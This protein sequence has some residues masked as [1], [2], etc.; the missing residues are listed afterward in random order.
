MSFVIE[1]VERP[2]RR[3]REDEAFQATIVGPGASVG[4]LGTHQRGHGPLR[5]HFGITLTAIEP[6]RRLR[7]LSDCY[8]GAR[9]GG[10]RRCNDSGNRPEERSVAVCCCCC[11]CSTLAL[12]LFAT[13]HAKK[14]AASFHSLQYFLSLLFL[15]SLY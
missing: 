5:S 6:K 14:W 4:Q 11:C 7:R 13:T 8:S 10:A 2:E 15:Y 9:S 3:R 1:L 12:S